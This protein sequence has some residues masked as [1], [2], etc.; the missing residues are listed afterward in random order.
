MAL[1]EL[2]H[3]S[4]MTEFRLVVTRRDQTVLGL[5]SAEGAPA[6]GGGQD[7]ARCAEGAVGRECGWMG[8]SVGDP[9]IYLG[10]EDCCGERVQVTADGGSMCVG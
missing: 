4:D 1:E 9:G 8:F 6:F 2:G 3:A 5:E 7:G 10:G